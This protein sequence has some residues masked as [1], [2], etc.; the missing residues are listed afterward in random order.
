M[1][2][3]IDA[4]I[5]AQNILMKARIAT[6]RLTPIHNK[7]CRVMDYLDAQA[8]ELLNAVTSEV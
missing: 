6:V 7:L 4:L 1:T 5:E 2:N 8:A 3:T